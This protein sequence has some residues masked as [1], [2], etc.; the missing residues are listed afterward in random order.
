MRKNK[1]LLGAGLLVLSFAG[2]IACQTN[3]NV[4]TS[5]VTS[6]EITLSEKQVEMLFGDTYELAAKTSS[7]ANLVWS[8][9]DESVLTV[10]DGTVSAVGAG[11]AN[12]I[13]S[14][15][16]KQA[17]CHFKV[18]FN[19]LLPTLGIE[20]LSSDT[21]SLVKGSSFALRGSVLFNEKIYSCPISVSLGNE[22]ILTL[23][24][25]SL[26]AKKSGTTNVI[27]KG[28]WNNFDN[29]LMQKTI[30]VTVNEDISMYPQIKMGTETFV[31][32]NLELS[33]IESWQGKEYNSSATVSFVVQNNGTEA[34]ASLSVLDDSIVSLDEN[35]VVKAKK[36]GATKLY[37]TFKD[38]NGKEYTSYINVNVFCPL[39][40]YEGEL[41]ISAE[42]PFPLKDY[43]GNGA[44]ILY[45]KQGERELSFLPNGYIQGLEAKGSSSDPLL[46]LTTKGGYYFENTFVYTRSLTK[47]NFAS[48]FLLAE[49]KVV[50]GYYILE[51]DIL[52]S[53]DMTKQIS[54]YYEAGSAKNRYFKGVFDG[55]GHTIAAKVAREGIFGGLGESA[56]IKNTHFQF[57][58]NSAKDYCSGLARNNWTNQVKGWKTTLSDLYVTT[59]NYFDHSYS[60]F[61]MRCNDMVME[62]IY[63]KLTLDESCKEVK[64]ATQE[65]GALFR[66]DNTITNGP[67]G[68]FYGDF[69]GVYVVS[70]VFMPMSSGYVGKQNLFAS[71]AKNDKEKLGSFEK[72]GVESQIMCCVLGSKNT[73]EKKDLFGSLPGCTWYFSASKNTTL[74]WI[75]ESMPTFNN[76]GIKRYNTVEELKKD[77][78]S[79]VGSWIVE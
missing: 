79:R 44:S 59:T 63:V 46:V 72:G 62:N 29:P 26:V 53:I 37:G 73:D 33:M 17:S 70:D 36:T 15:G 69:R 9:S 19:N 48:T 65:K 18:G 21:L 66:V 50:D 41:K 16:S 14:N 52:T 57:T 13:V 42:S 25:N 60:L 38:E 35:G 2:L 32:N 67:Y 27:V 5:E 8:S 56:T 77:N 55:Q 1:I 64:S 39:A 51:E 31:T 47:D 78:I 61:E 75:Y 58:F 4:S 76:G 6:D 24:G 40:N 28:V 45:A 7:P 22:E 71:Y 30:Q 3:P 74:A 54:S 12:I 68:S 49:G 43:F 10:D 20:N 11:E 23:D 34:K